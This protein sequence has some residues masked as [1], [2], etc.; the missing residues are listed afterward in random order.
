MNL[1]GL[2]EVLH[3][4]ISEVM[5]FPPDEFAMWL[6]YFEIR[7]EQAEEDRRKESMRRSS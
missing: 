1:F 3:K 2:A 6:A 5:A 4:S 7:N